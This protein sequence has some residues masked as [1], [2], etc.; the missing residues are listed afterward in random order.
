M[1]PRT[2]ALRIH[3]M[4]AKA[5]PAR[6]HF[7][8]ATD[9][10]ARDSHIAFA[11]RFA[12]RCG[13][14]A[15]LFH[16]VAIPTMTAFEPGMAEVP[17]ADLGVSA[18]TALRTI[19]AAHHAD[20]PPHVAVGTGTDIAHEILQAAQRDRSDLIVMPTHARHGVA[21]LLLG[22]VAE[23]V[24]RR[25]LH[26]VLL[27]TDAMATAERASASGPVLLATNLEDETARPAAAVAAGLARRLRLPLLLYSAIPERAGPPYGGGAAAAPPP[28]DAQARLRVRR[29]ALRTFAA[30]CADDL[31]PE[32]QVE[33]AADPAAAIVAAAARNG[34]AFVVVATHARRGIERVVL[35]SVAERVV[36]TSV[37]P[38]VC[39]PVR[40]P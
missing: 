9:L 1:V 30:E 36:R 20:T 13:A 37:I 27:L 24:L 4:N 26:P 29:A 31:G 19:A 17:I 39:V 7:L 6:A 15:T 12:A 35:G 10:P 22:S 18:R 40:N 38:V 14:H 2:G 11:V 28:D 32:A 3:R 16:C 5:P 8:V 33:V 34:A 25:S 23:R 21:R